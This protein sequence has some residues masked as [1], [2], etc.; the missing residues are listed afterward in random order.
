[1]IVIA[2]VFMRLTSNAYKL[3]WVNPFVKAEVPFAE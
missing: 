2:V 3:K 1:M